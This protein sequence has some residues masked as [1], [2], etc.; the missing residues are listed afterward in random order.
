MNKFCIKIF[1]FL[2]SISLYV[3]NKTLATDTTP[4]ENTKTKPKN[5]YPTSEE[6]YEKNK[7]LLCNNS[8]ET[9]Q[10]SELM[11]EAAKQLTYYAIEFGDQL[12]KKSNNNSNSRVCY[13]KKLENDTKVEMAKYSVDDPNEYNKI[14]N[15]LWD[16]NTRDTFNNGSA[17][18]ARVYNPNLVI[19]QQRFKK[20]FGCRQK[21]FNALATKVEIIEGTTVIV[22]TS[23]NIND[24]NPSNK[25]YKNTIIENANLF[26]TTIDSEEDIR[27]GKLN[28]VFVNI[29]GYFIQKHLNGIDVIFLASID[30]HSCI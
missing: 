30:G 7:H 10:A 3:N 15:E 4:E 13:K 6:I 11:S 12:C 26:K 17:K 16:P 9:K 18:I 19:I 5:C 20:K 1:F 28:K 14:I 23:A 24:H 29:A 27:S 21:Y 2:L 8:N 22:M 25:E